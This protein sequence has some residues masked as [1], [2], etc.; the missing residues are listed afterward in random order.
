MNL[1]IKNGYP[2]IKVTIFMKIIRRIFL[3][4]I[5]LITLIYVTNITSIPN[6]IVLFQGESLELGTIFGIYINEVSN[7][8]ETV[9]ASSKIQSSSKVEKKNITISLFNL[10]D[11][12]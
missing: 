8:Y 6:S 7:N 4:L 3:I 5:L 11:L 10:I 9:Q 1:K 2:K 12:K